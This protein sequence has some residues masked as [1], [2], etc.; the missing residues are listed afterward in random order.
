MFK[1]KAKETKYANDYNSTLYVQCTADEICN[2]RF[3]YSCESCKHNSGKK[4]YKNCYE[5]KE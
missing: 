3:T 5:R 2:M 1:R 4:T